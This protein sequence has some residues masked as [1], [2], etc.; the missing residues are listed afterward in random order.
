MAVHHLIAVGITGKPEKKPRKPRK[1]TL[2]TVAKQAAKAGI[3][4][5]RYEVEDGKIS[6][7][8]GKTETV[9][10]SQPTNGHDKKPNEWDEVFDGTH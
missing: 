2:A 9:A 7:V 10:D 4:V 6:I 8:T 5:A 3:A 1:A